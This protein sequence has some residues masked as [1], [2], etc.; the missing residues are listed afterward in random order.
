MVPF[1][2]DAD[3]SSICQRKRSSTFGA[4]QRGITF[5]RNGSFH[6][7]TYPER[8]LGEIRHGNGISIAIY[9]H[10][11]GNVIESIAISQVYRIYSK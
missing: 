4:S 5:R 6:H 10:L 8:A 9:S 3:E 11:S 1:I 7:R 2:W